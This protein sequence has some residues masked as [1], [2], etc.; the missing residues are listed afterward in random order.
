MKLILLTAI[1]LGF[2]SLSQ[3]NELT[4]SVITQQGNQLVMVSEVQAAEEKAWNLNQVPFNSLK[5]LRIKG[6]IL[7]SEKAILVF[8]IR[9]TVTPADASA[10]IET[11]VMTA[12][13]K[14]IA[15]D[16]VPALNAVKVA[17]SADG[18][19]ITVTANPE[20]ATLLG[21]LTK[22]NAK[23][24]GWPL[25]LNAQ[26][27]VVTENADLVGYAVTEDGEAISLVTD[28]DDKIAMLTGSGSEIV[29]TGEKKEFL[30]SMQEL[31]ALNAQQNQNPE[32]VP[33]TD[34][35]ISNLGSV[36]QVEFR[37]RTEDESFSLFKFV[38]PLV[39]NQVKENQA[40]N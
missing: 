4:A 22:M 29:I 21:K 5:N 13:E 35:K 7:Q 15:A 40:Q 14:L 30:S 19:L 31:E 37:N 38:S 20:K 25:F 3:A 18:D 6:R 10:V 11:H 28:L 8:D 23:A 27:Q 33:V 32:W 34:L 2:H 39:V 24:V 26:G 16:V 36:V 9:E 12:Q 1:L 17:L